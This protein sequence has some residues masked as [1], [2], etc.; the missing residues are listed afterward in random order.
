MKIK[1][2]LRELI[3]HG[4]YIQREYQ[5]MP[6]AMVKDYIE[7][8]VNLAYTQILKEINEAILGEIALSLCSSIEWKNGYDYAIQEIKS[9]LQETQ[10]EN[11]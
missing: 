1:E 11:N 7:E 4:C 9:K 5:E 6:N 3:H 8:R 2:I 10:N